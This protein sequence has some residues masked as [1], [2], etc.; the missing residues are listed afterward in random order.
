MADFTYYT[1]KEGDTWDMISYRA[2]G[3]VKYM[4]EIIEANICTVD[5]DLPAGTVLK[6]PIKELVTTQI[7]SVP[8]WKK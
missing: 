2:Y 6:I 8:F 5:V 1:T 7:D 3:D 4:C